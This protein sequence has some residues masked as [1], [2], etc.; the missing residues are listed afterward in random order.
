MRGRRK[1]LLGRPVLRTEGAAAHQGGRRQKGETASGALVPSAG[2]RGFS[3]LVLPGTPH[4][5]LGTN[6][7]LLAGPAF[8]AI[9]RPS[10]PGQPWQPEPF[11]AVKALLPHLHQLYPPPASLLP[12]SPPLSFSLHRKRKRKNNSGA[13]IRQR[14][15]G[16][17]GM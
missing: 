16:A 4:R 15:I 14:H 2:W 10:L 13:G 9:R 11:V 3:G 1:S 5:D 12:H 8:Q 6:R 17:K 7:G